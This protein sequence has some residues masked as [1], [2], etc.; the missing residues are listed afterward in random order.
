LLSF[1][2][3]EYYKS[4]EQNFP[5]GCIAIES[6]KSVEQSKNSAKA[7]QHSF[8]IITP[9]RNYALHAE[10]S[11]DVK[12][13]IEAITSTIKKVATDMQIL[14]RNTNP[15]TKV[16]DVDEDSMTT[17]G[18]EKLKELFKEMHNGTAR[19][20]SVGIPEINKENVET[21]NQSGTAVIYKDNAPPA[22]STMVTGS[23]NTL[24]EEKKARF[25]DQVKKMQDPAGADVI[26]LDHWSAFSIEELEQ[27]TES[28]DTL[29]AD[30]INKITKR[31][32]KK[33][34]KIIAQIALIEKSE[35][36]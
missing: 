33:K 16:L 14:R 24:Q 7:N 27:W 26:I 18:A 17:T 22:Y 13:W 36:K 30:S 8:N 34:R 21:T 10:T 3:V 2:L 20:N 11:T 28:I 4:P 1:P 29:L 9:K 6:I 31:C 19:K 32:E 5:L 23:D 35:K 12:E 25:L 15:K